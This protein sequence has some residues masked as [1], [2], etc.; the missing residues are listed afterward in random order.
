PDGSFLAVPDAYWPRE[1][2]ALE[3]DSEEFHLG[4]T[5]YRATLRRRLK[6]ETHGIEVVTV[7]PALVRDH[8]DE[9]VA[10]VLAK[11]R[12]GAGRREPIGVVVRA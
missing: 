7:A 4:A 9:V 10:A 11:L 3:V 6:L 5:A 2:V 8:P 1:G 12:L